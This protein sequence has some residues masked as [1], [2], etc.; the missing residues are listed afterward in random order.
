MADPQIDPSQVMTG[1]FGPPNP[2]P[3]TPQ[4]AV[5]P[6]QDLASQLQQQALQQGQMG[7]QAFQ[8]GQQNIQDLG[9]RAQAL[10]QQLGSL[11]RPKTSVT[12]EPWMKMQPV[13]HQ[14]VGADLKNLLADIGRGAL[15]GVAST[16]PG[17]SI[18]QGLYGGGERAYKTQSEN[19]ASQ[20]AD[21]QTQQKT[22]TEGLNAASNMAYRPGMTLAREQ[23]AQ[24]AVMNANTKATYDAANVELRQ[25]AQVL[26]KQIADGKLTQEQARTQMMGE[27]AKNRDKTLQ[28]IAGM[29]SDQRD[30]DAQVGAVENE[31]KQLM[32]HP[33]ESLL[34]LGPTAPSQTA[35]PAAGPKVTG[36][37][38]P[39]KAA[40][41]IQEGA[42]ATGPNNHKIKF[43]G[44]KWVDAATGK[45]IQ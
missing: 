38:P 22:A 34:G 11:Q 28:G 23:Q 2:A 4:Q 17:R 15:A 45:P 1:N 41:G 20:I 33:L 43:T 44:G 9:Q 31:Y 10:Q 39:K 6:G 29:Y 5:M 42:T 19:L 27:I 37:A 18:Q 7:S 24:A 30:R 13:T 40:T 12:D 21:I 35:T 3:P 16:G 8:Q 36:S 32:E 26:Q 25:K 14:G